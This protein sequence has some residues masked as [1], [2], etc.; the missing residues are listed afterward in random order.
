MSMGSMSVV[1]LVIL[2]VF[3]Q[4][5]WF[6]WLVGKMRAKHKIAGPATVG[7]PEF[8]RMFRVQQNTLES[9]VVLVPAMMICAHELDARLAAACGVL[10]MVGRAVY[11]HEY[12]NEPKSRQLG[13]GLCATAVIVAILGGAYGAVRSLL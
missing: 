10:F 5:L 11:K 4:Y 3:V 8:E 2:A 7:H 1:H 6:G 9:I 12:L 13:F